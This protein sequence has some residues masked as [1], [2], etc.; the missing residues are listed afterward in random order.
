V[1]G[2]GDEEPENHGKRQPEL[3]PGKGCQF[4]TKGHTKKKHNGYDHIV[5]YEV[6]AIAPKSHE[7]KLKTQCSSQTE[8][9][10][11]DAVQQVWQFISFKI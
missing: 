11:I 4:L 3:P 2:L 5:F 10:G 7:Q 9:L 8:I 1:H 6:E